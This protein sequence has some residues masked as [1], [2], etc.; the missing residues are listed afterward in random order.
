[1]DTYHVLLEEGVKEMETIQAQRLL[2][3]SQQLLSAARE[4]RADNDLLLLASVGLALQDEQHRKTLNAEEK[5]I[6]NALR[7]GSGEVPVPIG[8]NL[9]PA[10]FRPQSFYTQSPQLSDYF[11]AR[12]WYASVV[13]R[14]ANAR[15]TKSAA[16][17]ARL[18]NGNPQLLALWKQLSEP[19]DNFLAK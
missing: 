2:K 7:D 11:A 8:F 10:Q 5:R 6:V 14:L 12:Q 16:A 19:F 4:Q 3:F 9:S 13:F 18:V 15:E 17:L 1:W